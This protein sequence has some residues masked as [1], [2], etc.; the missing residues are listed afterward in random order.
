[1][2]SYIKPE[3]EFA[4]LRAEEKLA[5]GGSPYPGCVYKDGACKEQLPDG[6]WVLVTWYEG[7]QG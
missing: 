3:I 4:D 5:N 1:M 2:K 7:N 6:T